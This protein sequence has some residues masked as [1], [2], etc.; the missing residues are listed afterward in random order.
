MKDGEKIEEITK[1]EERRIYMPD[2]VG[3]EHIYKSS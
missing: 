2:R 3:E 1:V